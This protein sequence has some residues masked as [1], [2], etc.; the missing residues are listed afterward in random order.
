MKQFQHSC[1][2]FSLEDKGPL[3]VKFSTSRLC[4]R[5]SLERE[6]ALPIISREQETIFLLGRKTALHNVK[7]MKYEYNLQ[8][9]FQLLA[10]RS[11]VQERCCV[12]HVADSQTSYQGPVLASWRTEQIY[13][14]TVSIYIEI[15]KQKCLFLNICFYSTIFMYVY[16]CDT[17]HGLHRVLM[18]SLLHFSEQPSYTATLQAC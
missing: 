7:Q 16:S 1:C 17:H 5:I 9:T 18:G 11:V 15:L 13:H 8:N 14:F 10:R 2:C 4:I 12:P 3:E 6:R